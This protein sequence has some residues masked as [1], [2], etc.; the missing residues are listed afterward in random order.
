MFLCHCILSIL[1]DNFIQKV[2]RENFVDQ[3]ISKI[4]RCPRGNK[5]IGGCCIK[6]I[7]PGLYKARA[8]TRVISSDTDDRINLV[9]IKPSDIFLRRYR[10]TTKTSTLFSSPISSNILQSLD[11]GIARIKRAYLVQIGRNLVH[12]EEGLH[13]ILGE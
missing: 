9:S 2:S 12:V 1:T 13:L 10:R 5:V 3:A 8:H 6:S 4:M 11:S 7:D